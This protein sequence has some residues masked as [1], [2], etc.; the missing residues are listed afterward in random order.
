MGII[1]L[2]LKVPVTTMHT[3]T[4]V[5]TVTPLQTTPITAPASPILISLDDKENFY[6]KRRFVAKIQGHY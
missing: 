1:Q 6:A 3:P 2:C 4:I 5:T